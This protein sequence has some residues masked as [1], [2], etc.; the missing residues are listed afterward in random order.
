MLYGKYGCCK[1]QL[2]NSNNALKD[3]SIRLVLEVVENTWEADFL[4]SY[5]YA[6]MF[7]KFIFKFISYF[8]NSC[9]QF[10]Q[11]GVLKSFTKL[12]GK[13]LRRSL[14]LINFWT[15]GCCNF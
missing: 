2:L 15:V 10:C 3:K 5:M 12:K 11:I 8:R 6:N 14:F 4:A 7:F 9:S 1:R 13:H